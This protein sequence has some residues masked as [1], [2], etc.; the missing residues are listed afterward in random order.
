MD[1]QD[2]YANKGGTRAE[3]DDQFDEDD[4]DLS[5]ASCVIGLGKTGDKGEYHTLND[6]AAPYQRENIVERQDVLQIQCKSREIVHGSLSLDEGAEEYATLLVYD[7]HM[8]STKRSRRIVSATVKFEFSSSEP[9]RPNPKVHK[10]APLSRLSLSPSTQDETTTVGGEVSLA[11]PDLVANV[12]TTAKWEKTVNRTT[13]DEARVT[14]HV[15]S[16][17]YGRPVIAKWTLIENGSIK[18]GVP[19]FLRCAI[20]LARP[21]DNLFEGK[22][23]IEVE[24]DW[25]S[26]IERLFGTTP[27]DDPILFDPAMEPTN[28]LRK[29]GYDVDNLGLI[30]LHNEFVDIRFNTAF[31]PGQERLN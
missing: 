11:A 4:V 27:P 5:E 15:W 29:K 24:T 21:D 10:I 6:P 17:D 25:K 28:R 30:D 9:G 20:L 31:T 23:T 2:E 1:S 16:D 8:D 22:V 7:I 26:K 14:G 13:N 3:V 18:S 19:S 12:G